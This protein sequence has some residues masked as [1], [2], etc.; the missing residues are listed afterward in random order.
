MG[1]FKLISNTEYFKNYI[2]FSLMFFFITNP[3][4]SKAEENKYLIS[5]KQEEIKLKD[6]YTQNGIEYSQHDK[7]NSQL[8]MFFGF[9]SE[10][11]ETSFYPDL[12]IIDD[13]DFVRCMYKLKLNEMLIKK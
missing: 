10:N 3:N 11:P 4:F 8:K 13:S 6:F 12:L 7:T 2:S 5:N 9:E 1:L